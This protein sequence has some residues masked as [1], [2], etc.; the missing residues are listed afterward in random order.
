MFPTNEGFLKAWK[1]D[2][3]LSSNTKTNAKMKMGKNL[4]MKITTHL[5]SPLM[6]LTHLQKTLQKSLE[7]YKSKHLKQQSFTFIHCCLLL[8]NTLWWG[9]HV[10]I[11]MQDTIHGTK[12]LWTI[13]HKQ[14]QILF[15]AWK[16][17]LYKY[18]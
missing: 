8:N 1:L 12:V 15:W 7:I 3:M 14:D 16:F 9:V 10:E 4:L 6:K 13:Q 18:T 5:S 2:A 17:K 11:C